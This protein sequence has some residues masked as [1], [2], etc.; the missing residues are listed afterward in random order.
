MS[1]G[2]LLSLVIV[3]AAAYA[4]SLNAPLVFDD[5]PAIVTN[6]SIRH[7]WPP[8]AVLWPSLDGGL[9]VGGRPLVNLSLAFNHALGGG[10]VWGYHLFN[11]LVHLAA[12]LLLFGLVRRILLTP[13]L[14]PKFGAAALALAWTIAALWLLHPLQTESVTYIVQRA[15][16]MMGLFYLLTLYAFVRGTTGAGA[17]RGWLGLSVAACLLGMATKE[18]M[19]TAPLIVLLYDRTFVAGSFRAAWAARR[20]YYLGLG[21][22]WLLLGLL[23]AGNGSRGGTAGFGTEISSWHYALTQCRAIVHYLGLALWPHPLVFDYGTASVG[24]LAEVWLPAIVLLAALG[25][26]SVALVR[27]PVWGFVGAWFFLILSPSSS[28]VPVASQTMAEHRMYLPLAAVVG[29]AVAGL[30]AWI[31]RRAFVPLAVLAV[32]A[33]GATFARNRDYATN[34]GLWADTVAKYP[35]NGRAHNNLGQA[36]FE[37]GRP[38]EAIAS[39]ETAIRLEPRVP[40]PYRNLGLALA[41]LNRRAEAMARYREAIQLQPGYPEA[42][43]GLG[44][45]L[46]ESGQLA[47]AAGEYEQAIRSRPDFAEAHSNLA[48]VRLEQGNP[49][50]A[51][52]HG[53]TAV[54]LDADYADARYNLGNAFAQSRQLP[55]AREQYEAALRLRPD[56]AEAANNLGNVLLE[57]DRLPEAIAAYER[58]VQLKADY[59]DPRRNLA[60][61]LAHVGRRTEAIVHYRVFLQLRPDDSDARAELA[62]LQALD[63]R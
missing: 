43:N 35:A 31:G 44:N 40:E 52:Q 54:R 3:G 2:A 12:A 55:A 32:A 19:V 21:A 13:R 61:V 37:A 15:E 7:L 50:E 49:A 46:L 6:P 59:A 45:A 5:V 29:L 51:I 11:L 38:A 62:R 48:N 27:R 39:Y 36:L 23:V 30:Y 1:G 25:A 33:A 9:T 20:R 28:I 47:E 24:G 56:F 60:M 22:T 41:R 34:L 42:H 58:A 26:V 17:A 53:E 10:N 4:N 57:L 8:A 16:S 18:V 63:P 14:A